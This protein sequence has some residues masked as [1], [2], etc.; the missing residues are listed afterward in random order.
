MLSSPVFSCLCF[1]SYRTA[2]KN[3][4]NANKIDRVV[5]FKVAEDKIGIPIFGKVKDLAVNNNYD[6]DEARRL[7]FEDVEKRAEANS[8]GEVAIILEG[9][10]YYFRRLRPEREFRPEDNKND[11]QQFW[12][13]LD[14]RDT[15]SVSDQ[16]ALMM[17]HSDAFLSALGDS[18]PF[19][20]LDAETV[21]E[22][23]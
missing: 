11:R 18:N 19:L 23:L 4:G 6:F 20:G 14:A 8:K 3:N 5:D 1:V 2:K 22:F 21:F 16:I 15:D 12:S 10:G 13:L 7:Y 17:F 9:L